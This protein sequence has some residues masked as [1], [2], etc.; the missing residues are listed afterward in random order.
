MGGYIMQL[1]NFSVNDGEGIRTNVFLAGCPLRCLWCSNPEGQTIRNPMTRYME[2]E[3]IIEHVKRQMVFYRNSGGGVTF[4]G[5]EA[6]VQ[7]ECLRELTEAFY[8]MGISIALETC[9][10]FDYEKVEDILKKMDLIFYDLKHMDEERH[11]HFTGV[12]NKKIL[13]N[14][15][16]VADLSIPMVI[17]IP[18]IHGVNTDN[19]NIMDSLKFI[20]QELNGAKLEF[21]PYHTLGEGKYK[22][23]GLELP[24]KE[25]TRPEDREIEHW[26]QMARDMGIQV[27]SYK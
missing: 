20:K 22:E 7:T 3:E 8:D 6:T 13:S 15:V 14:A 26:A 21:L 12:S 23:L 24:P 4:S 27:V 2:T 25:F 16:R 17:R 11:R 9:G 18:V 1:Q 5:G 10:Y 19:K